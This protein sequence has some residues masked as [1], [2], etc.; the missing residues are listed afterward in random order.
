MCPVPLVCQ[1]STLVVELSP[2]MHLVLLPFSVII[3]SVLIEEF[4]PAVPQS[5]FLKT[6]VLTPCLILLDDKLDIIVFVI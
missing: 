3:A 4:S 2:P 5:I 1:L 6:L